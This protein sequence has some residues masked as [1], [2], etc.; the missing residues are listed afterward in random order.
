MR[1]TSR[2]VPS[3]LGMTVC[4]SGREGEGSPLR[5]RQWLLIGGLVTAALTASSA[6][7]FGH[8]SHGPSSG[9]VGHVGAGIATVRPDETL[10]LSLDLFGF[11]SGSLAS[12]WRT[13][14]PLGAGGKIPAFYNQHLYLL[15]PFERTGLAKKDYWPQ[16]RDFSYNPLWQPSQLGMRVQYQF[17]PTLRGTVTAAYF[18]SLDRV[19]VEPNPIELEELFG[20]WT[21]EALPG[22]SV[23]FGHLLMVGSYAAS[24]DQFPLES[25]QFNGIALGYERAVGPAELRFQLAGGRTPLGRTTAVEMIDPD[26]MRNHQNL[27]GVRERTHVYTTAAAHLASGFS[28]GLI[29]G[30]QVLPA[31]ETTTI[32]PFVARHVWRQSS[33]W[34]AG[35]EAGFARGAFG[36]LLTITHGWGDVEMATA[37]PDYVYVRETDA[38]DRFTREGSRVLQAV[39]SGHVTTRRFRLFTGVWGQWRRPSPVVRTYSIFDE[40]QQQMVTLT[41]PA[42]PFRAAKVNLEPALT[43]GPAAVG[44]RLDGILYFDKKATTGT[45][46]QVVDEAL[47][48]ATITRPDGTQATVTGASLWEREAVDSLIVSPFVDVWIGQV[49]RVR[50]SWSGAWYTR[51][52][53]RQRQDAAFHANLTLSA[54]LV[55]RFGVPAT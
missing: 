32:D 45:I 11:L 12:G 38:R 43:F 55:Y 22:F 7:A 27:D 29:A 41:S 3:N 34:H 5:L 40:L 51:P 49:V 14:E 10:K 6:A 42:Q 20:R 37:A 18:G 13:G 1:N 36:H 47:R 31:D 50:G 28:F 54:W 21:P 15:G 52:I 44:V 16:Y 19:T 53:H 46:E 35:V 25:F 26:P 23:S 2:D 48:P 39:Y 24:F 17:V 8:G 4:R 30:Y 33:G 9:P